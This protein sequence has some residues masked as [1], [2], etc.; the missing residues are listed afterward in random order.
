MQDQAK[1]I[2]SSLKG[3]RLSG[4]WVVASLP[5]VSQ[6]HAKLPLNAS[7]G[8]GR[9]VAKQRAIVA[10]SVVRIR[11]AGGFA[12]RGNRLVGHLGYAVSLSRP[13]VR[14]TII[15]GRL[16]TVPFSFQPNSP[17]VT[18]YLLDSMAL[19]IHHC[20]ADQFPTCR[21]PSKR[22]WVRINVV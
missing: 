19:K 2:C 13:P 21:G 18:P 16:D 12:P 3:R 4:C 11:L 1:S 20:P 17:T 9:V 22:F 8:V 14:R 5:L 10:I 15:P 6:M 7:S